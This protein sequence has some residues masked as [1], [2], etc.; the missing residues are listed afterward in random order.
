M[1][2]PSGA[3]RDCQQGSPTGYEQLCTSCTCVY[4]LYAWPD[5]PLQLSEHSSDAA[6]IVPAVA[7]G[8]V[9][10]FECVSGLSV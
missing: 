5:D 6:A 1:E 3:L 7:D 9:S 8:Q 2:P 4:W 10:R